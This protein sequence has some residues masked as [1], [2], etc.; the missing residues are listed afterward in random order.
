MTSRRRSRGRTW[1]PSTR[2]GSREPTNPDFCGDGRTRLRGPS[3]GG[4]GRR[5]SPTV[6]AGSGPGRRERGAETLR[7]LLYLN[8]QNTRLY[9]K[10]VQSRYLKRVPDSKEGNGTGFDLRQDPV[11]PGV[12][13]R[14]RGSPATDT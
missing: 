7:Y 13:I 1:S 11:D 8:Q 5:R 2:D 12:R 9:P 10:G 14:G 4:T 3:R 6:G